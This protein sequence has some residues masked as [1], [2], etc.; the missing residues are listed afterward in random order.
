[1]TGLL[2]CGLQMTGA[3]FFVSALVCQN[4]FM[5]LLSQF[6]RQM[7]VLTWCVT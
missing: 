5:P 6:W 4:R 3:V 1:M 2:V 7:G